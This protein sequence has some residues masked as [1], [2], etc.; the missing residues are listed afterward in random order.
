LGGYGLTFW[1]LV[2]YEIIRATALLV[3]A[4]LTQKTGLLKNKEIEKRI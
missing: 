1:V 4:A 2:K 3:V